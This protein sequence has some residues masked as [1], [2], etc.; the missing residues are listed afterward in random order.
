MHQFAT[1]YFDLPENHT[2]IIGDAV[3][4]IGD[5]QKAKERRNTHDY[6]IHDVFTGGAE[7][8]DLFTREFIMGLSELLK[9]DGII[10]IVRVDTIATIAPSA[11]YKQLTQTQNYGGDLRLPIAAS[12]VR[13]VKSVFPTCRLYRESAQPEAAEATDYTNMVMF[14]RKSPEAFTFREPTEADFL[15]SPARRQHLKPQHEIRAD[16]FKAGRQPKGEILR[17]GRISREMQESTVASAIGHW[18]L[19]RTV[20]PDV[21]WDN[22]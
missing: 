12:V 13:T 15:G 21:V 22:W 11:P 9:S 18:Y 17:R 10:A 2:S 5:M 1:K 8:I 14:C 7:P 20:L 19:M 6:I 3:V 16:Y 4:V